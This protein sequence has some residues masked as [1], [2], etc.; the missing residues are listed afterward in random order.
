MTRPDYRQ[1]ALL[2]KQDKKRKEV[3]DS[4]NEK[5]IARALTLSFLLIVATLS[6]VL[7]NSELALK[8][9]NIQ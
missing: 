5:L 1:E 9:F 2:S 4:V 6:F 8:L 7:Y 3:P